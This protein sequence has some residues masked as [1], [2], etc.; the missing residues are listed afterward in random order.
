MLLSP[1]EF[2]IHMYLNPKEL[3]HCTWLN[4]EKTLQYA[5]MLNLWGALP[6][7]S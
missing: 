1:Q 2:S 6:S 5:N 7:R 4:P 3:Y